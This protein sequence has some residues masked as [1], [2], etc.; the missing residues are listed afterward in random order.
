MKVKLLHKATIV[1]SQ[2]ETAG[3]I[4]IVNDKIEQV[5]YSDNEKYEYLIYNIK[6]NYPD[7]E[8]LELAG[9]WIMAGAL[10]LTCTSAN[11]A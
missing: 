3:S 4:L 11:Q 2:Q 5:I 6:K 8:V 1:T 7:L 10:M 9:K